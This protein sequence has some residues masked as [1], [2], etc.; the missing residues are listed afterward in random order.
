MSNDTNSLDLVGLRVNFLTVLERTEKRAGP[1]VLWRCRCICG[2][3][4]VLVRAYL[5]KS[6]RIKSCGCKTKEI[7]RAARSTH[8]LSRNPDTRP[9]FMVWRHMRE[10]CEKPKHKS[11]ANYGGRGISVCERWRDFGAFFNDMGPVPPGG[12]IERIDNEGNYEP[13]NCRWATAKEQANNRRSNRLVTFM[14]ETKT[15]MQWAESAGLSFDTFDRRLSLGWS[16]EDAL[17]KPLR[18]QKNNRGGE[19]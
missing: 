8:G 5:L 9:T 13:G 3:D 11:F 10:R 1:S 6:G 17:S 16:M 4:D 7:L 14:G 2:R 19:Q 15:L 18:R 12:T